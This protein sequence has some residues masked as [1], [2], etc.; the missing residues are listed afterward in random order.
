MDSIDSGTKFPQKGL[1]IRK[2]TIPSAPDGNMINL[3]IIQPEITDGAPCIFYIH[4]GGMMTFSCF[5]GNY[6]AWGKM[7]AAKGL[8]V[9]MVDF[10]NSV[11]P[12]SVP[13]VAPYPA[14]LNDCV[15][16]LKWTYANSAALNISRIIVAG[17][18][19]GGNLA[20]ASAMKLKRDG[21]GDLL[22]G[23]YAMCP[24]VG[25][26]Y[27]NP[28]F[29]SSYKSDRITT[30]NED[31]RR[32]ALGY[33]LE[34]LAARDPLAWPLFAAP[35]DLAG[36]PPVVVS[37]NECDPLREEGGAFHAALLA[38]G[39]A[40]RLR[41]VPG[42]CHAAEF[43]LS[44]TTDFAAATAADIAAFATAPDMAAFAAAQAPA[45]AAAAAPA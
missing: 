20:F 28:R 41:V 30:T 8:V 3:H 22:A 33:G 6:R 5:D 19:G 16:G 4:G 7:M 35:A 37:L 29:P 39:G 10:R 45:A 34:H 11:V 38:A 17:E 27:P 21:P 9:V 44:L 15:S 42:T 25:G 24:M 26:E 1:K 31:L 2:E 32:N 36:L 13:E 23:I 40:A 12:S 43:L 14:G 18:S